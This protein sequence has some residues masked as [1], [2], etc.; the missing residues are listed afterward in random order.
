MKNDN[1]MNNLLNKINKMKPVE[2]L[3]KKKNETSS[4]EIC[5]KMANNFLYEI[6]F[7]E[8]NRNWSCFASFSIDRMHWK[9]SATPFCQLW[10]YE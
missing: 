3:K 10:I 7:I 5:T 9:L 2:K 8:F 6:N 4:N 1:L